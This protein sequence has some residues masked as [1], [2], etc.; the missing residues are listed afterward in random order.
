MLNE[1]VEL[2]KVFVEIFCSCHIIELYRKDD[3]YFWQNR[4]EVLEA[5]EAIAKQNLHN[6]CPLIDK[7][8]EYVNKR[9]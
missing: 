5:T 7:Y 6:P 8:D 3:S 2:K 1:A 9:R 4:K